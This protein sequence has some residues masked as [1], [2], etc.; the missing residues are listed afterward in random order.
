MCLNIIFF[1]HHTPIVSYFI[2]HPKHCMLR[3]VTYHQ[4]VKFKFLRLG[5]HMLLCRPSLFWE[6]SQFG[7]LKLCWFDGTFFTEICSILSI[8]LSLCLLVTFLMVKY[9]WHYFFVQFIN[10]SSWIAMF[11]K[12]LLLFSLDVSTWWAETILS[13]T[14][15]IVFYLVETHLRK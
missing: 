2:N 1:L 6:L 13:C 12:L 15:A 10:G 3:V 5:K 7:T 8:L 14:N 9:Y 4:V 11:L